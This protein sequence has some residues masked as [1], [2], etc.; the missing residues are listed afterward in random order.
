MSARA[1]FPALRPLD[2]AIANH[3]AT[4]PY[5]PL[6]GDT[7]VYEQTYEVWRAR[8][9][10]LVAELATVMTEVGPDLGSRCSG[11]GLTNHTRHHGMCYRCQGDGWSARGRRHA[12]RLITASAAS[13]TKEHWPNTREDMAGR[14]DVDDVGDA[15]TTHQEPVRRK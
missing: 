5:L 7:T 10:G 1:M 4:F 12:A 13:T 14:Q 8:R 2:T 6:V 9:T 11:T 3:Q 15:G